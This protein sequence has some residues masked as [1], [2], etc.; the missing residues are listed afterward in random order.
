M[1]TLF[2]TFQTDVKALADSRQV[3]FLISTDAVDRDGDVI[4]P[5]GWDL[6]AYKGSP[7][8]LWSHDYTQ[9]PIAKTVHIETTKTG[10]SATAE[11]P[12]KGVY[13]FA[14]TVYELLKGGFLSASSVGFKPIASEKAVDR[15]KGFN[16]SKQELLEWSV[17]PVPA[18]PEALIQMSIDQP[19]CKGLMK[20]LV[21]WSEKFLG[22]YYGERGV[23]LPASQIE[24]T[25]EA[26][27]KSDLLKPKDEAEPAGKKSDDEPKIEAASEAAPTLELT[28]PLV[29]ELTDDVFEVELDVVSAHVQEL[30][31]KAMAQMITEE[32][33]RAINYARGRVQ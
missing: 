15:E 20:P 4:D 30:T 9:P 12:V 27:N 11:F 5:K 8:V 29:L 7:V 33:V 31:G 23:W 19:E 32:V 2:K 28:D 3:K 18:N 14:D 13:P 17:V 24:K 1:D 26:I 10:L 22:E 25:F 21:E 16:F 6:T